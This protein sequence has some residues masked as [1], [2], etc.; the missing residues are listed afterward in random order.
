[1][2]KYL[3]L[4]GHFYQPPR[5]NP[6]TG[7]IEKQESAAPYHDWNERITRECYA[8]NLKNY[9]SISF[10]FGPTL[11]S[12]LKTY[13]LDVH[14]GIV[15]ADQKS[16]QRFSGHGS[17]IAQAYNHMIMPLANDY[18]RLTQIIWGIKDFE[19]RFNR[20]PEGMWLPETA[21]DIAS[22]EVM[23][24]KEIKFTI[25][26]PNQADYVKRIVDD[27]WEKASNE[28]L[29]T[30][31][32]Y[33]CYL[34]SGKH[35]DIFFY[36][37]VL[38]HQVAFGK[39]LERKE[40]FFNYMIKEIKA[41]DDHDLIHLAIDG[42]TYGHHHKN[43]V[44]A[45][46]YLLKNIESKG[47]VQ[48]TNYGEF[49]ERHPSEYEVKIN[50]HTSWSC[51][52]GVERWTADCGCRL[53]YKAGTS[54][55]WREHLREA[56]DWLR[57]ALL[58][59]YEEQMKKFTDDPWGARNDYIDVVLGKTPQPKDEQARK[60]L[61]MQRYAMLMYTSCG[62]F[63]DDISGIETIQIL[64]YA[65]CA[66]QLAKEAAGVNLEESFL[67]RLERAKSNKPS[68]YNGRYIYETFVKQGMPAR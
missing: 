39:W 7:K 60:L 2:T 20:K 47:Q 36:D 15:K 33:R 3:C 50:E 37:G 32:S 55:K 23:V 31:R 56:L 4:H 41:A 13:H 38:A 62:W 48:L 45:L 49:L 21:V 67:T 18:D 65:A 6:W 19:F 5:E 58:P 12:W 17:A 34:P 54:Q 59:V 10:N 9:A 29:N 14:Q 64:Q 68:M 40:N 61:E 66:M 28:S 26:A 43:G 53:D 24:E 46:T 22:L 27:H 42:E 35:I 63:F 44:K 51:S 30:Q 8:R 52:H 57:D 25:L 11:L 1:M 16:R